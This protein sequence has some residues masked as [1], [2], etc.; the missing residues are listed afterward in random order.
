MESFVN[1]R[2]PCLI[3]YSYD[4][5]KDVGG[6]HCQFYVSLSFQGHKGHQSKKRPFP[7]VYLSKY[8]QTTCF[9]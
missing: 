3:K 8:W 1:S 9:T 2:H 6:C 4:D 7:Q 5:N